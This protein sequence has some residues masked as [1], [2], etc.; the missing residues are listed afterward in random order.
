MIFSLGRIY[1]FHMGGGVGSQS[2]G[3][4]EG[5]KPTIRPNVIENCMEMKEN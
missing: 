2:Q 4:M 5:Y 3:G 1:D